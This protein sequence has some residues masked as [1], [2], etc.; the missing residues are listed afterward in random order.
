MVETWLPIMGYEGLYEVSDLGRIKACEKPKGTSCKKMFPERIM[1]FSNNG[2]YSIVGLSKNS[3]RRTR[4]VHRLVALHFVPN[5][6]NLPEVNHKDGNKLNCRAD[7]LEWTTRKENERHAYENGLK[8]KGGMWGNS[9]AVYQFSLSGI[10]LKEWDCLKEIWRQLGYDRRV[11]SRCCDGKTQ[12]SHGFI[13]MY[14]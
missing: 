10:L 3:S 13:W 8:R 14:K 5:P 11:I 6:D 9:K 2:N 1:V 4:Y 12:S 7:N